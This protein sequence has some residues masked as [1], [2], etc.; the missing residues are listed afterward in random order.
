MLHTASNMTVTTIVLQVDLHI[1]IAELKQI[2]G[3]IN[4]NNTSELTV[5]EKLTI[6]IIH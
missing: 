5:E 4:S 1:F 6:V 3:E 2:S